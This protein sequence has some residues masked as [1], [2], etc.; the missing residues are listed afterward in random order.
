MSSYKEKFSYSHTSAIERRVPRCA[1]DAGRRDPSSFG[2]DLAAD[3]R[4]SIPC[5]RRP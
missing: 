2:F 1:R 5:L 4:D 3:V